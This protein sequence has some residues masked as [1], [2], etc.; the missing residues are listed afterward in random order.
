M[1]DHI[2][3]SPHVFYTLLVIS[4][5]IAYGIR[6][7]AL[8]TFLFIMIKVQKLNYTWLPLIGSAMLASAFDMIPIVGHF[9][10]VPV[11][12]WCVWKLTECEL[13]PDATFTVGLSY[14]CMRCLGW[15]M[16]AYAPLPSHQP[17]ITHNDYDD[18][19]NSPQVAM[20]QTANPVQ[21]PEASSA[22]APSPSVPLGGI[23]AD[24]S[25]KG[26]SGGGNDAMVTIQCGKKDYIVS[27]GE[28]TTVS[29]A[30]GSATVRFVKADEN[31]VTLSVS[32][33]EVKY[34]V[35]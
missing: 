21:A 3:L 35:R 22:P 26:I 17:T 30:Q 18:F 2:H 24:I 6:F 15:I 20:V 13:Y 16:L 31:N 33:Q 23:A 9:I 8:L 27:L 12:Y 29:T 11:L 25:V 10:A 34:A 4:I 19:T 1:P 5:A 28:G 32:G 7:I 14:A